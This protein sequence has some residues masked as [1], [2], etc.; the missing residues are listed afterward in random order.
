ME[1]M[2][3]A[4]LVMA[5]LPDSDQFLQDIAEEFRGHFEISHC[6]LQLERDL[7]SSFGWSGL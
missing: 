5:S 2:L 3:T 4:H 6:T 7:G 1:M